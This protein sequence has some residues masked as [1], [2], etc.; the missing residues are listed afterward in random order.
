MRAYIIEYRYFQQTDHGPEKVFGH[1]SQE[2]YSSLEDAQREIERHPNEPVQVTPMLYQTASGEEFVIHDI[3]VLTRQEQPTPRP[4]PY[5]RTRAAVAATGNRWA[6]E[7]FKAT[8][9]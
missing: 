9:G 7:N 5:E 4:G 2:G 3:R 8:H 1:I 6:M